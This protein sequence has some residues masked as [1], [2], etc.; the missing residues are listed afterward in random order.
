[1]SAGKSV[2][3]GSGARAVQRGGRSSALEEPATGARDT[4]GLA[5]S[6]GPV[7]KTTKEAAEAAEAM[8]FTRVS[9]TVKGQAVFRRGNRF[10]TRDVDGHNGGAWKMAQSPEDLRA[11]STRDG[12]FAA[13]MTR[14]G[15]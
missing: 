14:I 5:R 11:K 9:E 15:D 10:I 6:E 1:M 2:D 4:P 13:D 3:E 12:T 7:Y 8:G